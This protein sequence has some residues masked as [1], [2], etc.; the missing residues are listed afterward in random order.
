MRNIFISGWAT[1]DMIWSSV[2][3]TGLPNDYLNWNRV[4]HGD[5]DLPESCII[6]GW[7]LGGQLALDLS[8]RPE[9]RGLVLVASMDCM[10]ATDNRPGIE[11]ERCSM[12]TRNLTRSRHGYLR[13][14]VREC[15]ADGQTLEDL[16]HES[17]SF[18]MEELIGGLAVMFNHTADPNPEVPSVVIHGTED[19]IIPF[20]AAGYLAS[21]VLKN[22]RLVPVEGKG[23]LIS[24]TAADEIGRA[25]KELAG[26][27]GS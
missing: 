3:G 25:V 27:I 24:M 14:F 9:V 12:I 1:S 21:T 10:V 6:T 17:D 18:S 19:R 7:S 11:P 22:A 20:E 5:F 26:S 15:G 16:L 8:R 2:T 4:L 23:H 13:E